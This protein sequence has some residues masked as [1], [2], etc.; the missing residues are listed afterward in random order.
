MSVKPNRA[1]AVS[2]GEHIPNMKSPASEKFGS[3]TSF[4]LGAFLAAG[5]FA[6]CASEPRRVVVVDAPPPPPPPPATVV[7]ETPAVSGEVIVDAPP[8]PVR[9][10]IGVRPSRR[11]VW[12]SGYYVRRGGHYVWMSGHWALPPRGH[13]VYVAPHWE[14]RGGGY[15]YIEGVWR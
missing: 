7:A 14:H 6:G 15:I 5:L 12:V 11:H 4:L 2:G 1:E 10:V 9:E 3:K 8:P 13:T